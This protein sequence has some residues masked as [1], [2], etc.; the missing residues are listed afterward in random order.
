MV[1]APEISPPE[2]RSLIATNVLSL[3]PEAQ[4]G[5]AFLA[6]RDGLPLEQST[7]QIRSLAY[8]G[9]MQ[10][11]QGASSVAATLREWAKQGAS[12][13]IGNV[14]Y[15]MRPKR[16]TDVETALRLL[17]ANNVAVEDLAQVCSISESSLKKLPKRKYKTL[18]SDIAEACVRY[19]KDREFG[20][21]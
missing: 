15:G 3:P 7:P 16:I 17:L 20:K 18:G 4:P 14:S 9:V 8:Q 5:A 2:E 12:F 6:I 10:L 13:S 11:R 1:L 19:S 21:L